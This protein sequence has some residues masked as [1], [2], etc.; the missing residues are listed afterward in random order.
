MNNMEWMDYMN[1]ANAL[2][3]DY[4]FATPSEYVI[5]SMCLIIDYYQAE[6]RGADFCPVE[7]FPNPNRD[8]DSVKNSES[9]DIERITQSKNPGLVGFFVR[10]I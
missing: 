8:S 3:P 4:P 6:F 9:D 1:D 7:I 10:L 5:S 2:L